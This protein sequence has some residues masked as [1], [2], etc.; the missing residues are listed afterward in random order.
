M[1]NNVVVTLS[2]GTD[3]PNRATRAVFFA[4][5]AHKEGKN[6]TLFLLD[7]GVYIAKK[8]IT[9][10]LRAATGDS[11][12][13]HITYLQANEVPIL[14]CTPCAKSRMISENDLIEGAR[15]A[16]GG[17]LIKLISDAAVINL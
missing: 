15:M 5:V 16:T 10:N 12:D 17:E 7:E 13:D 9:E 11:A 6:I 8:G 3:D 4:M 14:V 1:T 2:C